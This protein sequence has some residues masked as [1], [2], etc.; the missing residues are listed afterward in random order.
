MFS[1]RHLVIAT[2][3]ALVL[4]GTLVGG[5]NAAPP[6]APSAIVAGQQEVPTFSVDPALSAIAKARTAASI[7]T[8]T[9]PGELDSQITRIGTAIE[10]ADIASMQVSE[11][12]ALAEETSAGSAPQLAAIAGTS[13]ASLSTPAPGIDLKQAA[14]AVADTRAAAESAQAELGKRRTELIKASARLRNTSVAA[15]NKRINKAREAANDA[16]LRKTMK[17][18]EASVPDP[19]PATTPG[20][21]ADDSSATLAAGITTTGAGAGAAAMAVPSAVSVSAKATS[22]A[23]RISKSVTWAKKVAYNNK[24]RY[25]YGSTGPTYFDC[26]GYT[27]KA[28]ASAGKKLQRTSGQQYKAAPAKVK[29]SKLKKGDLVFWSSNGG[30]SFYHVAL[31]IGSGK[32]AHARNPSAGI[33][34]T[35][36]NYAGMR[37]IYKYGGRY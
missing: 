8:G 10:D 31:Y 5:T 29:L 6:P 16:A 36:L 32:I 15:E 25:R 22:R 33:S 11:D 4:T 18:S 27:G 28:F 1:L 13:L 14:T 20:T 7:T 23:V 30:R 17:E 19:E 21:V 3:T 12:F 34:V 9:T 2:S 24:Y 26:S 37:N 35:K